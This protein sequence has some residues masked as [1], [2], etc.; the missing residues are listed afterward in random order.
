[1]IRDISL[2]DERVSIPCCLPG[3]GQPSTEQWLLF[4]KCTAFDNK[5][6]IDV[7]TAAPA[8]L[9]VSYSDITSCALSREPFSVTPQG[10]QYMLRIATV[11]F[12]DVEECVQCLWDVQVAWAAQLVLLS[13]TGQELLMRSTAYY[14]SYA[15]MKDEAMSFRFQLQSDLEDFISTSRSLQAEYSTAL[16]SVIDR[17]QHHHHYHPTIQLEIKLSRSMLP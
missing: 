12:A 5:Y 14:S 8:G 4:A 7:D 1:M 13:A 15:R 10:L 2:H 11:R 9:M 16:A 3:D 6:R 17:W